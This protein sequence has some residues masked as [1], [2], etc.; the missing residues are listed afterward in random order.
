[1]SICI[2]VIDGPT[3]KRY[4]VARGGARTAG[5]LCTAFRKCVTHKQIKKILRAKNRSGTLLQL[6]ES[7]KFTR[8]IEL[9]EDGTFRIFP[10]MCT[11]EPKLA[12]F[13]RNKVFVGP[14]RPWPR[15]QS[16]SL[17]GPPI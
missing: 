7:T 14:P 13:Q 1:M 3:T 12:K 16:E 15:W 4:T 2:E 10:T 9:R 11:G 17:W 6:K 5:M 8:K